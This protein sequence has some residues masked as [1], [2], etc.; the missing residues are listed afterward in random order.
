M[1]RAVGNR[2]RANPV[3]DPGTRKAGDAGDL[4]GAEMRRIVNVTVLEQLYSGHSYRS[5]RQ[6]QIL[7]ELDRSGCQMQI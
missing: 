6:R 1:K 7:P 2:V 3:A 5:L 4:T